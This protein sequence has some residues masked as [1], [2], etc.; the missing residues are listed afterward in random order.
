MF[1]VQITK[2]HREDDIYN[3]VFSSEIE[4]T[5]FVMGNLVADATYPEMYDGYR[6]FSY[7]P[8]TGGSLRTNSKALLRI[9]GSQDTTE[10]IYDT[11][12][13]ALVQTANPSVGYELIDLEQPVGSA[14]S[15]VI[16]RRP[17]LYSQNGVIASRSNTWDRTDA[18]RW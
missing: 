10:A 9:H 5:I 6:I 15:I 7:D 4:A 14:P 18:D 1:L 16:K 3:K 11:I 17:S 8:G 2:Q 12:E 13:E